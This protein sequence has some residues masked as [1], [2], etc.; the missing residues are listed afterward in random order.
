MMKEQSLWRKIQSVLLIARA[1]S[2]QHAQSLAALEEVYIKHCPKQD[3]REETTSTLSISRFGSVFKVHQK[4]YLYEELVKEETWM[5]TYGWQSSGHLIEIGGDRYLIFDP[6]HKVAYLE[7]SSDL[8][9]TTLNFYNQ[10]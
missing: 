8:K 1:Y 2:R 3:C 5:A 7:D 9:S 6:L 4:S 10:I